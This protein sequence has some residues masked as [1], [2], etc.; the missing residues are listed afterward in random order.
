M[1]QPKFV[2]IPAEEEPER[3]VVAREL[4]EGPVKGQ[5]GL[6]G[7]DWVALRDWPDAQEIQNGKDEDGVYEPGNPAVFCVS[8]G[9]RMLGPVC[10]ILNH[11][12]SVAVP[13]KFNRR[14]RVPSSL[15]VTP[16]RPLLNPDSYLL[17][18][19]SG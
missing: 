8:G 5:N 4:Y 13:G 18:F 15:P 14:K 12:M 1:A 19:I 11:R 7:V 6:W 17:V 3:S 10:G 9:L 2:D 16:I